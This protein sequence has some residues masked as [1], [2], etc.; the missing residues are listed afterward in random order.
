M[1]FHANAKVTSNFSQ[2]QTRLSKKFSLLPHHCKQTAVMVFIS[3]FCR[4]IFIFCCM[5]FFSI[6][7]FALSIGCLWVF[8][9]GR[10]LPLKA[11]FVLFFL[12]LVF[13]FFVQQP[14]PCPHLAFL[15]FSSFFFSIS[16]TNCRVQRASLLDIHTSFSSSSSVSLPLLSSHSRSFLS[17]ALL[18]R[19]F[20]LISLASFALP[21]HLLSLSLSLSF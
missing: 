17:C 11:F 2:R 5:R 12:T 14:H 3:R 13:W 16:V 6:R 9:I 10:S 7:F 21:S 18:V 15:Y 20:H 8:S 19:F 4:K 1:E